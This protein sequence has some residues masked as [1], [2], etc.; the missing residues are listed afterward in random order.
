MMLTYV[1]M[2]VLIQKMTQTKY[3]GT[4]ETLADILSNSL[5]PMF[6]HKSSLITDMAA[7]HDP[8]KRC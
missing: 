4:I 2:S 8:I 1:Y 6:Y 5:T 3:T 7:S